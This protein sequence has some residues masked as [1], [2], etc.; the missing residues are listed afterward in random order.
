MY[1][2][3]VFGCTSI[4]RRLLVEIPTSVAVLTIKMGELLHTNRD[5]AEIDTR[6]CPGCFHLY[7]SVDICLRVEGVVFAAVRTCFVLNYLFL[8]VLKS[9]VLLVFTFQK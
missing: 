3:W 5:P 2:N 7:E 1:K 6:I 8:K 9:D 4:C